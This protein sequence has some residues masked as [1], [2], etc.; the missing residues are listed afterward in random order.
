[1]PVNDAEW[2]RIAKSLKLPDEACPEYESIIAGYHRTKAWLPSRLPTAKIA[3]E[4]RDQFTGT[5]ETARKLRQQLFALRANSHAVFA[6]AAA[7]YPNNKIAA[8]LTSN[9]NDTRLEL[10]TFVDQIEALAARCGNAR[11]QV[12]GPKRGPHTLH[13]YLLVDALDEFVEKHTG[14]RIDRSKAVKY[15]VFETFKIADPKIGNGTIDGAMRSRISQRGRNN[16]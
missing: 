11:G 10:E 14:R 9:I 4:T 13:A 15:F 6:W 5:Q 16:G 8:I 3:A 2:K 12:A 7:R 1:M